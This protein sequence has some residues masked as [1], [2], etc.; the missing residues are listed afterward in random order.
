MA[1]FVDMEKPLISQVLINDRSTCDGKDDST[2]VM[3]NEST[4]VTT[5]DAF[6]PWMVVERK[7]RRN[8]SGKWNQQARYSEENSI[9]TRFTTL[10]S[11][12]D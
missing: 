9:G 7:S 4:R 11:L 1:V 5:E 6:G 10:S 8:Q 2:E 3:Y 12:E